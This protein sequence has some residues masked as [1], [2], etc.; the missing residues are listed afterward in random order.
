MT[1]QEIDYALAL[2]I[3]YTPDRVRNI[4]GW[5]QVLNDHSRC[6]GPMY[7]EGWQR[8]NHT[9][10]AVIWPIAKKFD[11]FPSL[12]YDGWYSCGRRHDCPE[13][14]TALALIYVKGTQP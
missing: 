7:Y 14:A 5:V 3:G 9:D 13:T 2:A 1:N 11:C 12:F 8:F 4:H 10:P 6:D